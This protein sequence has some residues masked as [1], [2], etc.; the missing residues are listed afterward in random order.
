MAIALTLWPLLISPC[1]GVFGGRKL[2]RKGFDA[3]YAGHEWLDNGA[4]NA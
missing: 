2:R 4:K 3:P 1:P